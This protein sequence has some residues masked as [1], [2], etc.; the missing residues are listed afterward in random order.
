MADNDVQSLR[1]AA[2][3]SGYLLDLEVDGDMPPDLLYAIDGVVNVEDRGTLRWRLTVG[4]SADI[5]REVSQKVVEAGAAVLG[6]TRVEQSLEDV[7]KQLTG[8]QPD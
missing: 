4:V 8:N 5:R 3:Q 6:L 2:N 1:G 7:F